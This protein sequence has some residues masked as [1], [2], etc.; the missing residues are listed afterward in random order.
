MKEEKLFAHVRQ[1]EN[2]KWYEHRLKE[3]LED[4]SALAEEFASMRT[5]GFKIREVTD[6]LRGNERRYKGEYHDVQI[7]R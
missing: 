7:T 4:T 2:G 1:D 3:H 6:K 5:L